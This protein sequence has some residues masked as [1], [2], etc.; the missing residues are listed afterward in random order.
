LKII[1]QTKNQLIMHKTLSKLSE[2]LQRLSL[3]FFIAAICF[4][5]LLKASAQERIV[6]G[7]VISADDS[8]T[9]PGVNI[10][11]KGTTNGTATDANGKYSISVPSAE[12]VLVFSAVGYASSEVIVGSQSVIDVTIKTDITTLSEVVVVGYGTQD[13]RE[14]TAAISSLGSDALSKIAT[15]STLEGMKGQI[16]GV[17][18]LQ[19]NGR[20]GSNAS[21]LIRGRRSIN[22]SNDPLFVVDGVPMS[23]GTSTGTDGVVSTS[24]SNPL[25]DFN[26]NDIASIE[27]LKDAAATAIYGSRGANGVVLITTKRGKSGKTN[28]SYSGYYGVT[29]P[30]SKFPMMNGA[31]FADLKREANRVTAA[32]VSG[33]TAWGDT[34]SSIPADAVVFIDPV[35]LASVQEAGGVRSTDWQDL[36]FNNGSQ[37]D[38]QISVS[39]GNDKTQINMSIGYF[40]QVGTIEG[41]DFTKITGRI[42]LDH[43]ISKR[44]KAGMSTL[45]SH[46]LLNNGSASVLGE[47]VNQTPLGVP[48]DANGALIFLPI[49]DGIRTNPLNEL[50]PNKRLD[51][52]KVDRIF[53]SAYLEAQI[54][55]GLKFKFLVGTDLRYETRGI[56]EGRFTQ[57]TKNGDPR[58]QYQ[59]QA[60][61]GY[62]IENLLTYNKTIG[63]KH[64][65]GLTGLF[66]V[67]EN[68]YENHHTVVSGVPVEAMKWYNLGRASTINA[69]RSR[70][71][72]WSLVSVMGRLNYSFNDRYLFQASLRADASSRLATGVKWT[73]FP[74]LSAA[75]RIKEEGFMSGVNF[76]SDLKFR[77][78]Y[79]VVGNT[80]IDPYKTQGI[81]TPSVYSWDENNAAGFG[82]SEIPSPGLGWEKMATFDVGLDFGLFDGKLSGTFDVYETNTTGLLLRRNIPPTTGYGFA[83]ENI[84]ATRTRGIEIGLNANILSLPNGLKWDADVNLASYKEEIVDLAQRG[85]NGE[86]ISDPGNAWF[87]GEPLRVFY[88]YKKIGIWQANEVAQAATMMAAYPGEIKLQDTDGNGTVTPADRVVIG[89]DVPSVYGGLNNRLSFK[90]FDLSFFLYYRLGYTLDS[91][92]HSDQATMQ[93]R[94]NNLNVDYWTINNPT[95]DYPRPN[96]NQE[97]PAFASTLRYKDG[98]FVKLRTVTLGYNLPQSITSKLGVS[99]L[100]IYVSA[101]NP[102]VW[103]KYKVFDPESVNQIDA[104]DVPSNKLYLGGINLTF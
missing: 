90:G 15:T 32:N 7:T 84:G 100:R 60:N 35:E 43:Q 21:V 68:Q 70:F 94:Y 40:N 13:K 48:Y 69:I 30:F 86:I 102:K 54:I 29:Q 45:Y 26:P 78:S 59:N 49:S 64:D 14:I 12:S 31:Q 66:S 5:T 22:A 25:N 76:V 27:V 20:P 3:G 19:S 34:G 71:E 36:I 85:P 82:L 97:N 61:V 104:G 53:S 62:T 47:A 67:Q 73:S 10:V 28:V 81:L 44:F 46:S 101:Q 92:F 88:D 72:P 9:V 11:V 23:S 55:E 74:G 56:F 52:Q 41:M 65:I 50:V 98:G 103:S 39:G 33:R 1:H 79:G 18:V 91:R 93:A 89:N 80:S 8:Q 37:T 17:D 87:I 16:A 83:F 99:N 6:T 96:K 77:L 42:N 63:G 75:W 95:N 57:N 58:A 24:G 2:S 4:G 38:H 51:E